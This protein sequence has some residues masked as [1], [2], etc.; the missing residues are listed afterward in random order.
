MRFKGLVILS[1]VI[2][3]IFSLSYAFGP[4]WGFGLG[5]NSNDI[6][7]T[8][9]SGTVSKIENTPALTVTI[10]T[11]SGDKQ[12]ILGPYWLQVKELKVGSKI[13]VEGFE[14]PVTKIFKAVKVRVD[15]KEVLN[16]LN[17]NIA[18]F[19]EYNVGRIIRFR[20]FQYCPYLNFS[21]QSQ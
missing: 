5:V 3:S 10:K 6:S 7:I 15:G 16:L 17:Q 20:G 21:S 18:N 2:L 12:V 9:I 4:K 8:K 11:T 14:S 19:R 13:E 1:L